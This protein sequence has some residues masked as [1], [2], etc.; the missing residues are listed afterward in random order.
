MNEMPSVSRLSLS[1]IPAPLE[2]KKPTHPT[3]GNRDCW[4]AR[5]SANWNDIQTCVI[6][7]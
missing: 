4:K 5:E 6:R 7:G 2:E 3:S 1:N